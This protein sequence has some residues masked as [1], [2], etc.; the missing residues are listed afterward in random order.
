VA[1]FCIPLENI[2]HVKKK[3]EKILLDKKQKMRSFTIESVSSS[4]GPVDYT[5]GRFESDT[6]DAAVRKMFTKAYHASGKSPLTI[7][8]RETTSGSAKKQF[9]K[10][11][12]RVP[13]RTTVMIEGKPV[14]FKFTTKVKS[15]K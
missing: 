14:T 8:F 9:K 15:L 3:K 4:S 5:G 11:V 2:G 13:D 7:T 10:R 1:H 12:T 6:P